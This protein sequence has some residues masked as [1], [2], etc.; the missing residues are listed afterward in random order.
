MRS[1]YP[2]VKVPVV[3]G[4]S[5]ELWRNATYRLL[6][7]GAKPEEMHQEIDRAVKEVEECDTR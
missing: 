2:R 4:L 7:D 5:V 1:R 3:F 6:R